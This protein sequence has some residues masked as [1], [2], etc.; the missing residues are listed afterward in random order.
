M[1]ILSKHVLRKIASEGE[2]RP[3]ASRQPH[4]EITDGVGW[5]SEDADDVLVV[6]LHG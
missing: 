4:V 3:G 1:N 6:V 2:M 5:T